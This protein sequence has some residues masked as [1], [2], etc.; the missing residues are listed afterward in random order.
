MSDAVERFEKGLAEIDGGFAQ[1]YAEAADEQ[2]LRAINARFVGAQG[3]LTSLMKLMRELPGDRRR[4]FG[5]RANEVKGKVTE[6]FEAR[7]AAIASAE[8]EAELNGPAIDVTLQRGDTPD[9]KSV[10]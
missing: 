8:R 1:Q 6:G 5:Q 4:E 2:S 9:R 7:L 3:S 10:V